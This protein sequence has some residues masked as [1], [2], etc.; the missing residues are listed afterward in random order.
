LKQSKTKIRVDPEF[1][2]EAE[3]I[4]RLVTTECGNV[5]LCLLNAAKVVERVSEYYRDCLQLQIVNFNFPDA[6]SISRGAAPQICILLQLILGAAVNCDRKN[7]FISD[8]MQLSEIDQAELMNFI[9]IILDSSVS[10]N[11]PPSSEL[12]DEDSYRQRLHE[13]EKE[14]SLAAEENQALRSDLERT[15]DFIE[16]ESKDERNDDLTEQRIQ[17][18]QRK[19]EEA[20]EELMSMEHQKEDERIHYS[21]LSKELEEWRQRAELAEQKADEAAMLQDEVDYLRE[22][23][24]Q[25]TRLQAAVESFKKKAEE[26]NSIK[27]KVRE[28]EDQV[29]REKLSKEDEMRKSKSY[30]NQSVT[31]KQQLAELQT[32]QADDQRKLDKFAE[33]VSNERAKVA[34]AASERLQA[35]LKSLK[36]LNEELSLSSD[37]KSL[38]GESLAAETAEGNFDMLPAEVREQ[39]IRQGAEVKRL[40]EQLDRELE[41]HQETKTELNETIQNLMNEKNELN[42]KI[43]KLEQSAPGTDALDSEQYEEL[44]NLLTK[45]REDEKNIKNDLNTLQQTLADEKQKSEESLALVKQK[46]EDIKAMETRYRSYLEKARSVIKTLDPK[47][48]NNTENVALRAQITEK[49]RIIKRLES[50]SREKGK[51]RDQE[52]KL[53]VS[54]WYQLGNRNSRGSVEDRVGRSQPGQ[55]FL[56]R[57]RQQTQQRRNQTRSVQSGGGRQ[58]KRSDSNSGAGGGGVGGLFRM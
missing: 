13:L 57:Q 43:S 31:A 42:E 44:Q 22:K 34:E 48:N 8:L 2:S 1:F 33:P 56:A 35:E 21:V 32:K 45:S 27:L 46:E 10:S 51:S 25:S 24:D 38:A 49:D 28:L 14:L 26:I 12:H 20:Q 50:E 36:D 39:M 54:A 4:N 9:Q 40:K 52:E 30:K 18:L 41:H 19:Y 5:D 17:D 6:E 58:K 53:L 3:F 16:R 7:D 11:S 15:R 47:H 23:A 37:N 55:S 29:D